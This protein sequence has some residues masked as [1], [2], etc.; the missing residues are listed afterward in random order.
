MDRRAFIGAGTSGMAALGAGCAGSF[1]KKLAVKQMPTPV[2]M[3]KR[4]PKPIGTMPYG[5]IGTTGIKVSKFGFGS[6][7]SGELLPYTKEREWM[8]REAYD[9]GVNFFD[10]YDHEFKIFQYEP[11]AK[12]LKGH[13]HDVVISITADPWD[14]RT[15]EQQLERDI[16]TFGKGYVDMV[17]VHAWKRDPNYPYQIGHTWD[18]W[19][20]LFK[21]KEKGLIR[22]VGVPVHTREDLKVPLR[23]LPLDFVIFPYSFYHNWLWGPSVPPDKKMHTVVPTLREKGIGVISMKPFAGD[24]LVTP[25]KKLAAQ[26]DESGEVSYAQA[27]LRQVINSGL[28]VDSTLRTADF[29]SV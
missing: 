4:L 28:D 25:F 17:R 13:M 1:R 9:L 26:Y 16:R 2:E 14:G 22:A 19:E 10:I 20:T 3:E 27:C 6:H 5:E 29:C 7:M 18:M 24:S 23:D 11:T 12:Y 21:F 8:I 15:L